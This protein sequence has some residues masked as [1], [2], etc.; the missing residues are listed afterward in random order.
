MTARMKT[1]RI[2][3]PYVCWYGPKQ[4]M[5]ETQNHG[6][7]KNEHATEGFHMR[8]QLAANRDCWKIPLGHSHTTTHAFLALFALSLTRTLAPALFISASSLRRLF[9]FVVAT[10]YC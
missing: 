1:I 5:A 9:F 3:G 10:A 8:L 7:E 6:R 4:V 2:L